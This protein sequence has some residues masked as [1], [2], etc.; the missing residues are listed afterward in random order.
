MASFNLVESPEQFAPL[1]RDCRKAV[2]HAM[3]EENQV[4]EPLTRL[5][6]DFSPRHPA[7]AITFA[8]RATTCLPTGEA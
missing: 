8:R 7:L 2:C 4:D 6:Y 3:D 1:E 5:A